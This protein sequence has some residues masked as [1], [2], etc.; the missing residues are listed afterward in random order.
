MTPTYAA[1]CTD[2][3]VNQKIVSKLDL[4][5]N[6]ETVLEMFDRVRKTLP[7]MDRFRRYED[8]I[9][10][11][12]ADDR[13]DYSWM[14]LRRTSLRSGWVNPTSLDE[15]YRLHR[16]ILEAAPYFLSLSPLDVEYIELVFGFDLE[17]RGNRSE[18]VFDA[19]LADSPLGAMIE[20]KSEQ[21][22]DV[23]PM[24]GFSLS[25][26]GDVQAYVEIKTRSLPAD[27]PFGLSG[28]EP[29]MQPISVYLTAR[30]CGPLDSIESFKSAFGTLAGS[31]ERLAEERV[32]PQIIMPLREAIL[33][34]PA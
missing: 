14:A 9:A 27:G 7:A 22:L 8:E 20:G 29:E 32:I 5:T 33:L 2:F 16:L 21:V 28:A 4:P 31:A 18:I 6:R 23:Q 12:S 24:L 15:A 3:Y 1:L 10:L 25:A 19:L 17:A 26:R 11:E 13:G 30:K 34:H